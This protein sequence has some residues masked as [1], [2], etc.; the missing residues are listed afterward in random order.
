MTSEI[1]KEYWGMFFDDLTKRRFDWQTRIEVIGN[2]IGNQ[3]LD[4]GLPLAGI[5][6]E[7]IG[8]DDYIEIFVGTDDDHH[9]A[10]T[11]KN[12]IRI[13]YS[14]EGKNPGGIIEF[15][16]TDGTKT[17][18]HIIQPMPLPVKYAENTEI[19]VA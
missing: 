10:H 17:L 2:E 12:P 6:C 7:S 15:E 4:K 3:I 19:A 9:Q 1:P 13:L 11:I 8:E 14:G 16:E 18:V 5:T